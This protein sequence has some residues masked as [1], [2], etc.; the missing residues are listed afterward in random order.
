VL[1]PAA[2][3]A[4]YRQCQDQQLFPRRLV[5]IHEFGKLPC[6]TPVDPSTEST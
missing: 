6:A 1:R 2:K 5:W 4:V 3:D